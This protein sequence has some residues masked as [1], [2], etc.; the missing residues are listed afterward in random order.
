M[1]TAA[2]VVGLLLLAWIALSASGVSGHAGRIAAAAE[3]Q[4]R[5]AE[6]QASLF[7]LDPQMPEPGGLPPAKPAGP[8]ENPSQ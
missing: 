7:G 1:T 4:A 2:V 6:S 5:A 8:P 3:R